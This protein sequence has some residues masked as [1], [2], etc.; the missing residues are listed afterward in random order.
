MVPLPLCAQHTKAV[1]QGGAQPVATGCFGVGRGSPRGLDLRFIDGLVGG[2]R[3]TRGRTGRRKPPVL[4]C[5]YN[6]T[7]PFIPPRP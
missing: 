7:T 6:K 1:G 3:L 2:S 5:F 4:L